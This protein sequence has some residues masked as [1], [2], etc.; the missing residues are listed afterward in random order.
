VVTSR[1][2]EALWVLSRPDPDSDHVR[3]PHQDALLA[4]PYGV[5]RVFYI[6]ELLD[7]DDGICCG[8]YYYKWSL[9]GGVW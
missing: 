9:M 8:D 6:G 1:C 2:D 5:G 7:D 4:M 3:V